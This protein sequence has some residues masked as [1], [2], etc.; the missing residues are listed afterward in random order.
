MAS[1]KNLLKSVKNYIKHPFSSWLWWGALLL[2]W[3]LSTWFDRTWLFHDQR[4]PSWDQAEYLSSALEHGRGLG[5]LA[6]REWN[7]WQALLDLSPK[8]PPLSALISGSV[9]AFT[10]ETADKA[11]WVLS[12]WHGLLLIIVAQWGRALGGTKL[13]LLAA[14]LL[15]LSP[16]MAEHRVEFS[17]DLAVATSS[18]LALWLL[19]LW[20]SNSPEGGTWKQAFAAAVSIGGA[21][22][23]KQ[24]SLL[25]LAMPAL[26][27]AWQA[28][29]IKK[30]RSQTIAGISVVISMLLPWLHHNWITTIGGT[31]RA[32]LVSGAEEGDPGILNLQ[33]WIW[34]PKL[35]PNQL[36]VLVLTLGLA[37]LGLLAWKNKTRLTREFKHPVLNLADGW[38]W[39]I[40]VTL[41]GWICIT[42]SPN[43]DARYIAPVLPLLILILAKGWLVLIN[44]ASQKAG[45]KNSL[46]AFCSILILSATLSIKQRWS[47]IDK[48][49][50]SPAIHALNSINKRVKG[51]PTTV[52][53]TSSDR[54]LNE[55]TLSYLGQINGRDIQA[56]R[57]GRSPG[58][59]DMAL[60]QS[61]WW[62][63]ATGDQGTS[64][65]SAR[66]LGRKVR[67][68]P[69]FE[70]IES[71]GWTEGREVELWKRKDSAENP[72]TF[73]YR[74]ISLAR[75][76]EYG[77]GSLDSIFKE[78]EVQHL[79]DPDFKYQDRVKSWAL[80]KLKE[81]NHNPDALW[82]LALLGVLQNRPENAARWFTQLE[83]LDAEKNWARAYHLVVLLADWKSCKAAWLADTY[84]KESKGREKINL[85]VALRDLSR[86]TCFDPRGPLGLKNSIIPAIKSVENQI[87][88]EK[89]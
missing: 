59:K 35:M 83:A 41:S 33:S 9:M 70:L 48:K 65:K 28:F 66:K 58:Q 80:K 79:L 53:I 62:I 24:S 10:G 11:S 89:N 20:Q 39:V 86:T 23:I 29:S 13:G 25:V 76:L 17:L 42:L 37:G 5:L 71:W 50:G 32:V 88:G 3:L 63:L 12:L 57:L 19:F 18:S 21:L 64:R 67:K 54:N 22:L 87:N 30:R 78:I 47:D 36:G 31:Q 85:L 72:T 44:F 14:L 51:L 82:S 43:K 34:Y 81:N 7:G 1:P 16:A 2:I 75:S 27:A 40:G 26:W 38:P 69:R 55:Q 4:L 45:K 15:A 77:P 56:R 52:F 49:A 60:D 73:D 8:I 46:I 68:D 6:P 74:F 84:L 61:N